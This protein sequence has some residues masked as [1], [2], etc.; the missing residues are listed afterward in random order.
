MFYLRFLFRLSAFRPSSFLF[1]SFLCPLFSFFLSLPVCLPLSSLLYFSFIFSISLFLILFLF[2]SLSSAA[3]S[4]LYRVSIDRVGSI[5][6]RAARR[7][8]LAFRK[9][10][11][12]AAWQVGETMLDLLARKGDGATWDAV[13]ARLIPSFAFIVFRLLRSHLDNAFL[14]DWHIDE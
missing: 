11:A 9:L 2:L 1:S 8:Y 12:P 10:L 7:R 4:I 5:N 6:R 14:Y 13:W 3:C